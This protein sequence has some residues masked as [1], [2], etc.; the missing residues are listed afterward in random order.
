[1]CVLGNFLHLHAPRPSL[2]DGAAAAAPT[3]AAAAAWEM[4]VLPNPEENWMEVD[5]SEHGGSHMEGPSAFR[6][7]KAMCNLSTSTYRSS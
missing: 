3:A 4:C 1:M 5:A 2:P 7:S 6:N